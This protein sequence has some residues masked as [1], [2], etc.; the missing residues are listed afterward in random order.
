MKRIR[1]REELIS[2]PYLS[3]TEI[4]RL[5]DVSWAKAE[6]I[7]CL[8][9][10]LDFEDLKDM[11][12]EPTKVRITSV[13]KVIGMSINTLQKLVDNEKGASAATKQ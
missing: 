2:K 11:R 1:S 9:D 7:F 12:I 4:G 3:K 10:K 8:A 6:R 13:C 5:L